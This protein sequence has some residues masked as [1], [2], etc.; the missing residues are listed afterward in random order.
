MM[1][2]ADVVLGTLTGGA[3][4]ELVP[5]MAHPPATS[6]DLSLQQF[7]AQLIGATAGGARKGA[8][9][10][11]KSLSVLDLALAELEQVQ[12]QVQTWSGRFILC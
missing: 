1:L 8:K 9:L 3:S 12:Q 7:L 5:V 2:E 11:F 10:D 6:S 4:G